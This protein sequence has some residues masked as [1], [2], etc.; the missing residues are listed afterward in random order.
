MYKLIIL[1]LGNLILLTSCNNTTEQH[2]SH[3]TVQATKQHFDL[4]GFFESELYQIDKEAY[5]IYQKTLQQQQTDSIA[6]S[7]ADCTA[8]AAPFLA[9]NV[10]DNKAFLESTF[11]DNTTQ[12]I[13][14]TYKPTAPN[15]P[16]QSVDILVDEA[17]GKVKRVFAK[18]LQSNNNVITEQTFSWKAGKSFS[19]ITSINNGAIPNVIQE[20]VI[21]NEP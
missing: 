5:F 7:M 18:L 2:T 10:S 14:L 17:S 19:I 8:K 9:L 21:W 1:L 15:N 16:I 6:L 4:K 11:N 3:T 13:T 12:S 20:Q